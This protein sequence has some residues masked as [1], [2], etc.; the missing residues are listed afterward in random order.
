MIKKTKVISAK[1]MIKMEGLAYAQGFQELDF[2]EQAGISIASEVEKFVSEKKLVKTATLLVGKGNNGGDAYVSGL[3]LLEK[4][5][6]VRAF[7][8]YHT[9]QLGPLCRQQKERF[10]KAGGRIDFVQEGKEVLF[11]ADGI[12]IDG[13]V[14]TGFKGKAEGA[15]VEIIRKAN[16]SKLPIIAIDIPSGVCGDTGEVGSIAIKATATIYLEIPK[17]GFFL[18][19]G[20]NHVGQLIQGK[21]GLPSALIDQ[22]PPDAF[23]MEGGGDLPIVERSR[24]KYQAGYVLAVAGSSYMAGAGILASYAALKSG[25]GIVRWFYPPEIEF[26][27]VT[28]PWEVIKQPFE[29]ESVFFKELDRAKALLIGPGMGREKQERK[30]V[31]RIL[32]KC[33]I[34]SVIDADALYFLSKYPFWKIPSQ[35]LL[36]PHQGEL[37][38]LLDAFAIQQGNFLSSCQTLAE[39]KNVSILVKGGPNFLFSPHEVPSILPFGN[40]GMATAGSGDVLSGILAGLLSQAMPIEQAA[41]LG[42]YL[43]GMAGD[44]A[45]KS[46]TPFSMTASDILSFLPQAFAFCFGKKGIE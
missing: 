11:G 16:A 38:R 29:Q 14:G 46:L 37:A 35:S 18:G 13:L 17:C 19:D 1:S 41:V 24:H 9:E 12:I 20:W 31:Q 39:K 3:K 15:L 36:T 10:E 5:F 4:G 8:L 45:A 42:C 22:V 43:H 30:K 33:N 21:F 28:T 6:Q 40:P 44:I 2:M 32:S 25:A 23:L 27:T 7:H 34:P 26:L